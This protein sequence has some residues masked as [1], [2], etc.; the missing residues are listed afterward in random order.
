MGEKARKRFCD[1]ERDCQDQRAIENQLILLADARYG[2]VLH[3]G[4]GDQRG[5]KKIIFQ[6]RKYLGCVFGYKTL[7]FDSKDGG[8]CIK[9]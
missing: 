9:I 5:Y 4:T 7:L 2:V 8:P 1:N 3:K 6:F